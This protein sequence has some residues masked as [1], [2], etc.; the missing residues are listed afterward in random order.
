[1]KLKML[2]L[3][4]FLVAGVFAANAQ[5]EFTIWMTG[6]ENDSLVLQTAA[7]DFTETT[8]I[9]VNVEPVGWGEAYARFLTA[10]NAGEGADMFAGGMSW[11]ISLGDLGGLISLDEAFAV[12]SMT[13]SPVTTPLS[14]M[15]LSVLTAPYM[16]FLMTK[17]SM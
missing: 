2:V 13:S 5:D 9:A 8:G 16:V 4:I 14:S 7:A 3:I 10:I 15:P 6:G 1:M 12:R 17:P 11:G